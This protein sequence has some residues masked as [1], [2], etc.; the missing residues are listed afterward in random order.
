[1]DWSYNLLSENERILLGRLSVFAAG[2][3]LDAVQAVCSYERIEKPEILELLLNFVDKSL[4]LVEDR[5]GITRYRFLETIREYAREKLIETGDEERMRDNH[6]NYYDNLAEI[7][8]QKFMGKDQL[9]WLGIMET[10]RDNL[11]TARDHTLHK[12]PLNS[13]LHFVGTA[14]WLWFFRGPWSEGQL[15]AEG[16]LANSADDRTSEK[17]KALLA[18]GLFNFLQSDY[19]AARLLLEESL[20]IWKQIEDSW[21]TAFTLT[22]LGRSMRGQDQEKVSR[23]YKE[24]LDLARETKESWILAFSLWN[25]GENELRLKNLPEADRLLEESL[26]LSRSLE[27]RMLQNEILHALGGISESKKEF[28]KAVTLYKESLALVREL[29]NTTTISAIHYDLGRA[30]QLTGNN[31][32]AARH[33]AEA[34]HW[35]RRLGKKS[36]LLR[37]LGGL[38]VVATARGQ[39]LRGV[40]LLTISKLYFVKL[41]INYSSDPDLDQTAWIEKSLESARLQ[42]GEEQY[43]A[44]RIEGEAM[45]LDE[46]VDLVLKSDED[47]RL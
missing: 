45:T 29:A 30:L 20:E 2:W 8:Q 17:A 40:R 13:S 36:G 21:W 7:A 42:L 12:R 16:A 46:A 10:E 38:G 9:L 34:L 18:C 32:E 19:S 26:T 14:F 5:E 35:S 31:D 33:F 3:T 4:V 43:K 39:I 28:I 15:W 47:D 6:L 44:T 11:R 22:F 37:A 1:M 23:V 27:D 41:G 24:S 25:A